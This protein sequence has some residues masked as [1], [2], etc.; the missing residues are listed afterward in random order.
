MAGPDKNAAV[1]EAYTAS[2]KLL[3]DKKKA[4][5]NA[6]DAKAYGYQIKQYEAQIKLATKAE[7]DPQLQV[8]LLEQQIKTLT[9]GSDGKVLP[10]PWESSVISQYETLTRDL[11]TYKT[12]VHGYETQKATLNTNINVLKAKISVLTTVKPTTPPK[13]S[14][15]TTKTTSTQPPPTPKPATAGHVYNLPMVKGAYFSPLGPQAMSTDGK[16]LDL[17]NYTDAL[18][19]WSTAGTGGRGA[20]QMDRVTNTAAT[21]A[22]AQK[23][24]KDPKHFDPNFYGFKFLYNPQTVSMTWGAVMGANPQFEAQGHDPA[25]PIAANLLQSTISFDIIL[26]RI[27]DFNYLNSNG[28]IPHLLNP[29]PTNKTPDNSELKKVYEK[30]TM[31]DLDYLFKTMHGFDGFTNYTSSLMGQTNDPGWLP[32]RP[33]ELHLGNKLRYRVRITDLSVKHS[34]FNE[35]MIPMLSTVSFTCARYWDGPIGTPTKKAG[36]R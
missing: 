30:G 18:N 7:Q 32:V 2:K 8:T 6:A 5:K 12:Q 33:V 25:V 13:S 29:Y 9:T 11:N 24:S 10:T 19:S 22:S 36:T 21:L 31:Y 34:I 17:G 16:H 26:N 23:A 20:F 4:A 1:F 14:T 28:L 15:K 35:R 27:E 3:A